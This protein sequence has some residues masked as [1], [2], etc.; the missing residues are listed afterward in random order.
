MARIEK[1]SKPDST[2]KATVSTGMR[3]T[4]SDTVRKARADPNSEP[5]V[6]IGKP[7]TIMSQPLRII[8][9]PR[10]GKRGRSLK[11]IDVQG[12]KIIVGERV[13]DS[14]E[15]KFFTWRNARVIKGTLV[16]N[17]NEQTVKSRSSSVIP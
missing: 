13:P 5:P 2:V 10:D 4:P 1:V 9:G 12:V 8:D 17:N 15:D 3:L 16:P 11:E 6:K 7:S 14:P